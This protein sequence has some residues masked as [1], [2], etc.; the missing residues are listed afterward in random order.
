MKDSFWIGV[1]ISVC[2]FIYFAS[3]NEE[4]K[5]KQRHEFLM[6]KLEIHAMDSRFRLDSIQEAEWEKAYYE[7]LDKCTEK[8]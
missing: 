8:R 3:S 2:C 4:L 1:F 7:L 6:K 5:L